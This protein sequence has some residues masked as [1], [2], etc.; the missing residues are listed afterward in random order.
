MGDP[1][2]GPPPHVDLRR[3]RRRRRPRRCPPCAPLLCGRCWLCRPAPERGEYGA[4]G[5]CPL[6]RGPSTASASPARPATWGDQSPHPPSV[7]LSARRPGSERGHSVPQ[8]L[9]T[10]RASSP[11]L[12][13]AS[14][15]PRPVAPHTPPPQKGGRAAS[16]R[17]SL[18]QAL[19]LGELGCFALWFCVSWGRGRAK[20]RLPETNPRLPGRGPQMG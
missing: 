1:L 14:Y 5:C 12:P 9:D 11:A 13:A 2:W 18:S 7:L 3:R 20:C 6:R 8:S 4:E 10:V 15:A 16:L 17:N 19:E